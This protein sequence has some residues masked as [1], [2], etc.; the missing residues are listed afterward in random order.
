MEKK[1]VSILYNCIA[2][3]DKANLNVILLFLFLYGYTLVCASNLDIRKLDE[4]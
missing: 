4:K 1:N 3:W 2:R